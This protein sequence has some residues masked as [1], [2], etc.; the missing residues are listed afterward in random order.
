MEHAFKINLRGIIDL[1]SEHLYSGPK[2][3]IRELLQNAVDAITAE[4]RIENVAVGTARLAQPVRLP[5]R[6]ASSRTSTG[7]AANRP[8][9]G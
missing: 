3:Y 8:S 4:L 7:T 5:A 9:G 1:L 6:A 2:V